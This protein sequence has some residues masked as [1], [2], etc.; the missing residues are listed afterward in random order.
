MK[1]LFNVSGNHVYCFVNG[2]VFRSNGIVLTSDA[3]ELKGFK[4]YQ[5]KVNFH[6]QMIDFDIEPDVFR[7]P[8]SHFLPENAE[9]FSVKLKNKG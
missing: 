7:K 1:A 6:T 4:L 3:I 8:L 9:G 5:G 2:L